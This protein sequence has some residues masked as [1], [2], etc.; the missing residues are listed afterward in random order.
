MSSWRIELFRTSPIFFQALL[1][2]GSPNSWQKRLKAVEVKVNQTEILAVAAGKADRL[3]QTLQAI[4]TAA[5]TGGGIG[6]MAL[7]EF[8]QA[9]VR[10]PCGWREPAPWPSVHSP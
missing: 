5:N 7:L 2:K 4:M 3:S 1:A 8:V 9:A 10:L 6:L